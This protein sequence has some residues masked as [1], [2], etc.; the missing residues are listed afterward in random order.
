MLPVKK[1]DEQKKLEDALFNDYDANYDYLKED[2]PIT[3]QQYVCMSFVEPHEDTVLAKCKYMMKE[4]LRYIFSK[5]AR[6]KRENL[7]KY[8]TDMPEDEKKDKELLAGGNL[9]D[10]EVEAW[11]VNQMEDLTLRFKRQNPEHDRVTIRGFKV[12]GSY[13]TLRA[14][15]QQAARLKRDDASFH[16][17]VGEV[18]KWCPFNPINLGDVT[19]E[20]AN[21]NLNKIVHGHQKQQELVRDHYRIRK[22]ALMNRGKKLKGR[23]GAEDK[24]VPR[25]TSTDEDE[26]ETEKPVEYSPEELAALEEAKKTLEKK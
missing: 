24:V 2:P 6:E 5:E 18:G 22:E 13:P 4:Y 16:I 21:S 12:R 14:A 20:F 25:I 9:F 17:F 10:E 15:K 8:G 11:F 26:K 3:N 19:A 7:A 1:T 23:R